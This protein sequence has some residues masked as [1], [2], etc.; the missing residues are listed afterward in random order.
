MDDER[1]LGH[2]LKKAFQDKG[3]VFAWRI[4]NSQIKKAQLYP[5]KITDQYMTFKLDEEAR[6]LIDDLWDSKKELKLY[7]EKDGLFA[8]TKV[9]EFDQTYLRLR[10]PELHEFEERRDQKRHFLS[11]FRVK[12]EG[13]NEK[14]IIKNATDLSEGGFS[15]VLMKSEQNPFKNI[16]HVYVTLIEKQ[17][18]ATA[19][20]IKEDY[21]KPFEYSSTPYGGRRLAFKFIEKDNEISNILKEILNG[22]EKIGT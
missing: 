15:I 1:K 13:H 19:T 4:E 14:S 9:L 7:F 10:W 20:V 6:F 5:Y 22:V 18:K 17:K 12:I 21:I 16:E 3:S 11:D 2:T 8:V